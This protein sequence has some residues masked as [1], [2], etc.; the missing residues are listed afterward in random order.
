MTR[1]LFALTALMILSSPVSARDD[2]GF[3]QSF[4]SQTP[5]ALME[6][7]DSQV[8]QSVQT[9]SADDLQNIMPAA[10][11]EAQTESPVVT[12]DETKDILDAK[13]TKTHE[14][15]DETDEPKALETPESEK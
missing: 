3:G 5:S 11:D 6:A 15:I 2:G 10:G 1:I 13:P 9:P 8:A 14:S 4:T 12:K 7:P